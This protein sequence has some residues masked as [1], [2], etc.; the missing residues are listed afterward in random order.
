M[1]YEIHTL[2]FGNPEWMPLCRHS[3]D[4]FCSR[5]GV[6]LTVWNELNIDPAYPS[7]KFCE[8]D[9]L[10]QFLAGNADRLVYFDSDIYIDPE[11]PLP[12]LSEPGFHICPDRPCK[13]IAAWPGWVRRNFPEADHSIT[14]AWT[15]RNAGVWMCDRES[16]EQLLAVAQPPFIESCME[17]DQ[18]NHWLSVAVSQGMKLND[19]PF[20]WNQ[21][22]KEMTKA[23]AQHI[24]GPNK[25]R[26]MT[27]LA[28]AGFM[29]YPPEPFATPKFGDHDR[30]I[31][32]P[33]RRGKAKWDE[34]RYALRSIQEN[35]ADKDC[36]IY[37]LGDHMPVWYEYRRDT[38]VKF[39]QTALYQQ[40]LVEGLCLAEKILWTNDDICFLRPCDWGDFET[41]VHL[42]EETL[43]LGLSY[44]VNTNDW[45]KG[46]GRAIIS[47][48]R[49]HPDRA[50]RN[51]STHTPYVFERDKG[52][53]VMRL[54]GFY[55]K[56]PIE[57][58]YHNHW[59]T[60]SR[61]I[62]SFKTISLP[63]TEAIVLN[64]SDA[65]LTPKVMEALT[66]MFPN[67]ERW[68]LDV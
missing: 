52:L 44:L 41:P 68:E 55:H 16:A 67:K 30:A 10:R 27:S 23:F 24:A 19:L 32:L 53:E 49:M 1:T 11:A 33:W 22:P 14:D 63:D 31:V 40:A 38:R 34:L 45:R 2:R 7:P 48:C 43:E 62:G 54:F 17:Q 6:P 18:W 20:T 50:I 65:T 64:H 36:P 42:N 4:A 15:Y 5:H 59:K 66:E 9:M 51:F 56:I 60:P 3:L 39:I 35:F 25:M 26:K 21:Y 58:L 12:D 8:V 47:L 61:E 29:P 28:T 46:Y 57:T 13:W 37:I